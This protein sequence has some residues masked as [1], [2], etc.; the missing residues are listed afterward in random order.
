M[1]YSDRYRK[2]A[3]WDTE[4]DTDREWYGIQIKIQAESGMGYRD[5]YRQRVV[6]DTHL[7]T[8]RECGMGYYPN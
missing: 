6:W 8:D 7:E 3:A 4:I 2:R 1:G 5:I